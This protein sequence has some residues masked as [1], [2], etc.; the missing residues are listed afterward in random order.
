MGCEEMQNMRNECEMERTGLGV[1]SNSVAFYQILD[2]NATLLF[3]SQS[4]CSL[5][6]PARHQTCI[7]DCYRHMLIEK[8]IIELLRRKKV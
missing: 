5:S 1:R 3:A 8:Y 4:P 7:L 2:M 6:L